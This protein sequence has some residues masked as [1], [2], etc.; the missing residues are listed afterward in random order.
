MTQEKWGQL[1][2]NLLRTI[3]H[4][5]YKNWIEPLE[6]SKLSDVGRLDTETGGNAPPGAEEIGDE[7]DGGDRAVFSEC[8]CPPSAPSKCSSPR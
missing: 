1:R 4:N 5:N 6:F 2:E 8:R 7:R 3:G